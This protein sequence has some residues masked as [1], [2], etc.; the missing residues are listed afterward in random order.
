[1]GPCLCWNRSQVD[2][3]LLWCIE[4]YPHDLIIRIF[5]DNVLQDTYTLI[6]NFSKIGFD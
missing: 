4:N 2:T 1:V 5:G 3:F 6:L